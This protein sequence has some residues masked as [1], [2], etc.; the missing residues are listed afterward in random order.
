MKASSCTILSVFGFF[1]VATVATTSGQGTIQL[2]TGLNTIFYDNGTTVQPAPV[3]TPIGIF[4]GTDAAGASAIVG[5]GRGTLVTPTLAIGPVAG[6]VSSTFPFPIPGTEE[7][8]RIWMK[9]GGWIGS[10]NDP[11]NATAY[12][13]SSV[14]SVLLGPTPGPGVVV[15]VPTFTIRVVPEP[16]VLCLGLLSLGLAWRSIKLR[17]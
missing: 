15:T 12:G 16:S 13:E 17:R 10:A 4:W 1:F 14:F 8:Q 11:G 9:V 6:K 3:G 5:M 7:G 2:T